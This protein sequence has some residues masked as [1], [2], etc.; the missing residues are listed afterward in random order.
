V[1]SQV[2]QDAWAKLASQTREISVASV[3]PDSYISKV[4][5]EDKAVRAWYDSH[6]D[7]Y[8]NPERVQLQYVVLT[9]DAVA[10][11]IVIAPDEVKKAFDA[12]N[13]K[14]LQPVSEERRA[15][16]ILLQVKPSAPEAERQATR[17]K[18]EQL[19][20][21]VKAHPAQF[22]QLAQ[23]YSQDPGSAKQGGD[24]GFFGRGVMAKPFEEAV[25][26]LKTGETSDLVQTEFGY[27]I[28]RLTEVK[29]AQSR[30]L[31]EATPDLTRELRHQRGAKK[32][33]E[34]ADNFSNL[35]FEQ[36]GSLKPAA[37]ALK[38]EVLQTT[39]VSRNGAGAPAVLNNA[40][41]IQAAFAQEVVRDK[42]NT[43]AIEVAPNTL[44]AAR[45]LNY[46]AATPKPFE[47]VSGAIRQELMRSEAEKMAEQAGKDALAALIA[48]KT[49]EAVLNFTAAQ[50]VTRQTVAGAL[51]NELV[52]P[53]FKADPAQLPAYA[54][55]ALPGKGF[56]LV[57]VS[58]VAEGVV[59]TPEVR[60][61]AEAALR[62]R[63]EQEETASTVASLRRTASISMTKNAL[64][65]PT[66]ANQE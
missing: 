5:V 63:V 1:V 58:K 34:A 44:V 28:I 20:A 17:K 46:E 40:K 65:T 19:L 26:A 7:Q 59:L 9:A 12:Q 43:S 30:T 48:G 33:V 24:L 61:Q 42:R 54:G 22:A 35:V 4:K 3:S 39:W 31:A 16:H 10:Q 47:E 37:D 18:A 29:G 50:T 52:D 51:P 66:R 36:S 49:P 21:E 60:K 38:L 8:R 2:S 62:S 56:G 45:A 57:R 14:P 27:H 32:F 41:F 23:K 6:I 55:A 11:D 13:A 15:A 25:F 64:D 53:A